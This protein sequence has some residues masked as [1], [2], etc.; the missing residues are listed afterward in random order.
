MICTAIAK[1]ATNENLT[2]EEAQQAMQEIMSGT[3]TSAQMAAYLTALT[4]K[5]ET[6]DE[7]LGSAMVIRQ[8]AVKVPHHQMQIVDCC[9]TGGDGSNTFNVSTIVAFIL[10]AAGLPVAK[11]G[12]RSV[13]SK[14]GSADLLQA[15]GV[16]IGLTP[17]QAAHCIDEIGIG[18]LFAPLFHPA[19]KNVAPVRKELGIRTIFNLLG[20]LSNP[21]NATNQLIGVFDQNLTEIIAQTCSELGVDRSW[22]VHSLNNVDEL[23]PCEKNKISSHSNG[24]VESFFL[25]PAELGFKKGDKSDLVGGDGKENLII[26]QKILNGKQGVPTDTVLLNAAAGLLVGRKVSDLKEGV[27]FAQEMIDSRKAL[28]KLE[29]LVEVSNKC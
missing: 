3:A 19:M 7:I 24:T 4:L 17:E 13:S 10:A 20:P 6:K 28:K 26:T 11:H 21:A 1:L 29:E 5:G 25:D 16:K 8:N 23:T 18:F 2:Q 27:K 9:G 15:A 22:V 12:N 14:C